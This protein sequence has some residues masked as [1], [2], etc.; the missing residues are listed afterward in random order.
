MTIPT[1][2]MKRFCN[3]VLKLEI[4]KFTNFEVFILNFLL[5]FKNGRVIGDDKYA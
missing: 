4:R 2:W 5:R 1:S 3:F